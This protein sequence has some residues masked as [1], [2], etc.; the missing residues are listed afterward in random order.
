MT[1]WMNSPEHR[2]NILNPTYTEIG[3]AIAMDAAGRL[4]FTQEF[5]F[6]S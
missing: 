4:F 5:G 2:A 3:V 6:R 1:A